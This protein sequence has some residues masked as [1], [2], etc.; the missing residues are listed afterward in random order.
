MFFVNEKLVNALTDWMRLRRVLTYVKYH[1]QTRHFHLSNRNS[2][3]WL[4]LW[5]LNKALQDWPYIHRTHETKYPYMNFEGIQSTFFHKVQ[6][7]IETKTVLSVCVSIKK[8]QKLDA[9]RFL[10]RT[11]VNYFKHQSVCLHI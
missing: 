6:N 8:H 10:E 3:F 2:K 5:S 9:K 11:N 1:Q 4:L 7:S